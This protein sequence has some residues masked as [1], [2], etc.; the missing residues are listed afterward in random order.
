MD[1][2][3]TIVALYV[4]LFAFVRQ[5]YFHGDIKMGKSTRYQQLFYYILF[6]AE[7]FAL[8]LFW[9]FKKADQDVWWHIWALG[10]CF[11]ALP[12]HLILMSLYY[13]ACH[14]NTGSNEQI[15]VCQGWSMTNCRKDFLGVVRFCS[16]DDSLNNDT[17]SSVAHQINDDTD[18]SVAHQ[19]N[20]DTD[21]SVAHQVSQM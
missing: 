20:D 2:F 3:A 1:S 7:N 6:H 10:A 13:L 16:D 21:S 4:R 9:Y 14:P 15:E 17:D 5:E 19:I 12:L 18:S 8:V 11:L